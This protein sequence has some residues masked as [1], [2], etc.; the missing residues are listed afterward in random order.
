MT[1]TIS[2]GFLLPSYT[3]DMLWLTAGEELRH[4]LT[5]SGVTITRLSE[6]MPPFTL[7]WGHPGGSPLMQW[8]STSGQLMW[9]G[10][11]R[12]VGRVD[13]L[14]IL[15][16]DELMIME[17]SGYLRDAQQPRLPS[18]QT[19]QTRLFQASPMVIEPEGDP[20]WY[21]FLMPLDSPL[22]DL[23]QQAFFNETSLE[24]WGSLAHEAPGFHHLVGM[25]FILESLT[26]HG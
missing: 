18:L 19:L 5:P 26:V 1:V 25:P 20:A 24:C 10:R 9:D 7:R 8:S 23:A 11:L 2:F 12:M 3:H 17:I 22:S 14:H 15:A 13:S 6:E 16:E 21:A 4:K